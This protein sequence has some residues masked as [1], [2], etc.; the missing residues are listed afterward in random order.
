MEKVNYYLEHDRER[1]RIARAGHDKVIKR[2]TY[3]KKIRELLE[4]IEKED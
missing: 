4:W 3:E 1:E 2:F